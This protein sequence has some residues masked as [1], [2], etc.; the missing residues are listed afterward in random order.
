MRADNTWWLADESFTRP[1][2]VEWTRSEYDPETGERLHAFSGL[3]VPGQWKQ[4][5]AAHYVVYV[6]ALAADEES[7][8]ADAGDADAPGGVA[9]TPGGGLP[10]GLPEQTRTTLKLEPACLTIVRFG[11][12]QGRQV[13]QPGVT[14]STVLN[15]GPVRLAVE[16]TATAVRTQVNAGGG[17]CLVEALVDVAGHA[18]QM[19]LTLS[20]RI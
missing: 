14:T 7:G 15:A 3:A 10:N 13:F 16:T 2:T 17:T 5:G 6:E 9:R 12:M 11:Y 20:W 18:E 8:R 4:V 1:V 19:A